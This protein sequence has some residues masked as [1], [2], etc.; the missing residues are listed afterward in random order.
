[1]THYPWGGERDIKED[2][3]IHCSLGAYFLKKQES[4]F[5]NSKYDLLGFEGV[6]LSLGECKYLGVKSDG[7]FQVRQT[8][9]TLLGGWYA[10]LI[11]TGA[12]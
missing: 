6:A 8:M 11:D 10:L 3:K 5:I 2:N 12:Y 4:N 7:C 1:M 9:L